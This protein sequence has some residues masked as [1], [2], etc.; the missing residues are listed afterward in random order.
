[1]PLRKNRRFQRLQ[2]E[3]DVAVMLPFKQ[4]ASLRP[5]ALRAR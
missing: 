4:A 1:V 5:A 2:N 3:R